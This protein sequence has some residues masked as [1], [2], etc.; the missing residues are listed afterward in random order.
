VLFPSFI[1]NIHKSREYLPHTLGHEAMERMWSD[2]ALGGKTRLK[3]G[4]PD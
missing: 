3:V 1:N 4:Y 2:E